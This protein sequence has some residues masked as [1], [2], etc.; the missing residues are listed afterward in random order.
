[1]EQTPRNS[2]LFALPPTATR[3]GK[4]PRLTRRKRYNTPSYKD[5]KKIDYVDQEGRE[6]SVIRDADNADQNSPAAIFSDP[7]LYERTHVGRI[8]LYVRIPVRLKNTQFPD[9][10]SKR[11]L[12]LYHVSKGVEAVGVVDS[13]FCVARAKTGYVELKDVK[14]LGQTDPNEWAHVMSVDKRIRQTKSRS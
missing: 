2:P 13:C 1:M 3:H 7:G 11:Q 8:S 6:Y 14:T 12:R 4:I 9:A 10:Q 5:M